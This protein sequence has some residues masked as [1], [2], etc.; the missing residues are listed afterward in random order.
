MNEKEVQTCL[1]DCDAS[2]RLISLFE[3]VYRGTEWIRQ[4]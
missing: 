2:F 3:E 4:T 1:I